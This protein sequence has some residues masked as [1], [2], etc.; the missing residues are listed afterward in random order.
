MAHL[1]PWMQVFIAWGEGPIVLGL[2][3]VFQWWRDRKD[4]VA[5]SKSDAAKEEKNEVDSRDAALDAQ[6]NRLSEGQQDFIGSLREDRD[7]LQKRCDELETENRRI[8][9]QT[10]GILLW[11]NTMRNSALSARVACDR[12]AIRLGEPAHAWPDLAEWK[13][14]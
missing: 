13:A 1:T 5:R 8:H 2:I 4:R 10:W 6:F 9:E 3:G 12:Q 14:G 7:T 11:G